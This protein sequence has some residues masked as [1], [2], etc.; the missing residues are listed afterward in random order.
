MRTAEEYGAEALHARHL[1]APY[2]PGRRPAGLGAGPAAPVRARGRR[3]LDPGRPAA[4]RPGRR[5][6]ARCARPRRGHR[7]A[8]RRAGRDRRGGGAA[9]GRRAAGPAAAAGL[10]VHRAAAAGCRPRRA[11]GRAAP[12]RARRVHRLDRGRAAAAPGVAGARVDVPLDAPGRTPEPLLRPP[13]VAAPEAGAGRAR[14]RPCR[15]R[16]GGR[17]GATS[18]CRARAKRATPFRRLPGRHGGRAGRSGGAGVRFCVRLAPDSG[19]PRP[20]GW[21]ST[22]STTR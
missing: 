12:G 6:A 10:P 4:P 21:S 16:S 11:V 13:G 15:A 3:R 22:S 18:R 14:A 19:R 5:A 7:A 20:A 8:L 1:D 17:P 2:R 9:G